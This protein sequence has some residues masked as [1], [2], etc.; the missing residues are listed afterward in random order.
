LSL[1]SSVVLADRKCCPQPDEWA[2]ELVNKGED[3]GDSGRI[4]LGMRILVMR[5]RTRQGCV[6]IESEWQ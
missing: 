4:F 6:L 3:C 1:P 2:V 5:T